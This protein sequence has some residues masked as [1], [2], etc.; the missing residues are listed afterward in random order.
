MLSSAN[1]GILSTHDIHKNILWEKHSQKYRCLSNILTSRRRT[2]KNFKIPQKQ[3][4]SYQIKHH[5]LGSTNWLGR[6]MN[7]G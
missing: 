2:D 1:Y 5:K 4:I 6:D 3:I 7:I